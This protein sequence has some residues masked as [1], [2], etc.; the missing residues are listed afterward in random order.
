MG[1]E[2]STACF[3][4]C[5]ALHARSR[6]VRRNTLHAYAHV[7]VEHPLHVGTADDV[8]GDDGDERCQATGACGRAIVQGVLTVVKGS[9]AKQ[10]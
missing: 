9:A 8:C 6:T 10:R 1:S 2:R 7:E 4:K 3:A 5:I